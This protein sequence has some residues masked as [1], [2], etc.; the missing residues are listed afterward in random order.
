M[1]LVN[2]PHNTPLRIV[3]LAGGEGV[4]RRL[5]ALGFHKGD[6]KRLRVNPGQAPERG[7]VPNGTCPRSF[8]FLRSP[9]LS[10]VF[11]GLQHRHCQAGGSAGDRIR[12]QD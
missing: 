9:P 4:R 10:T 1:N 5:M 6:E 3:D 11:A 2:A 12:G 7:H 8:P